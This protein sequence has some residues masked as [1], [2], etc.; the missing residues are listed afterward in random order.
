MLIYHSENTRVINS[1]TKFTLPVPQKWKNKTTVTVHLFATWFIEYLIPLLIPTDQK[2]K[3]PFKMLLSTDNILGQSRVLLEAYSEINNVFFSANI[4]STP[5]QMIPG[6]IFI[7]K[8]YYLRNIS[9]KAE[10]AVDDDPSEGSGRS[11]LIPFGKNLPFQLAVRTV[12]HS[13]RLQ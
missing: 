3:I 12:I 4:A 1:C 10:T 7:F 11:Q 5:H 8:S 2:K 13:R 9:H 6:V